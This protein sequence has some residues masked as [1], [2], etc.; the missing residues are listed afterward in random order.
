VAALS[1]L[2][3]RGSSG[4]VSHVRVCSASKE[5]AQQNKVAIPRGAMQRRISG[6]GHRRGVPAWALSQGGPD[7]A[8]NG[9]RNQGRYN[10]D[11]TG[12]RAVSI[13]HGWLDL[14]PHIPAGAVR[15]KV[16]FP[17]CTRMLSRRERNQDGSTA[18]DRK[19]SLNI[20]R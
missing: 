8:G 7:G 10:Q 5:R 13:D 17:A 6:R 14:T 18:D 12:L 3:E 2:N 4:G 11:K 9:N 16:I 15:V 1:R 19:D 20:F